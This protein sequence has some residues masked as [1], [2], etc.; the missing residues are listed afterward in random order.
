MKRFLT[1]ENSF[2]VKL[3]MAEDNRYNPRLKSE[4]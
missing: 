2:P 1:H 3:L 4:L